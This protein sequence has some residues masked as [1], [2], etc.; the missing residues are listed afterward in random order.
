[1]S[2]P[3]QLKTTK[4]KKNNTNQKVDKAALNTGS[5]SALWAMPRAQGA[6]N[7]RRGGYFIKKLKYIYA[8][9]LAPGSPN[10]CILCSRVYETI[11]WVFK[12][13]SVCNDDFCWMMAEKEDN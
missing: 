8:I 12:V 6:I 2:C 11:S 13:A 3:G 9:L 1:M 10:D 5:S 7:T 4:N